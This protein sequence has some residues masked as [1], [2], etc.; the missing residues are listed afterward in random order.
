MTAFDGLG[1][2]NVYLTEDFA[3]PEGAVDLTGGTNFGFIFDGSVTNISSTAI[4][5]V[6]ASP[7]QVYGIE[8]GIVVNAANENVD[9]YGIDGRLIKQTVSNNQT[10]ELPKGIY[11][12]KAGTANAVK[13]EVR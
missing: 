12:V 9:I 3:K 10:I 7:V 13:V 2:T 6:K 4:P 5:L 1:L 11:I 8:G